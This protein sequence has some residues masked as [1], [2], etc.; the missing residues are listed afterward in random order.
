VL[1]TH[2]QDGKSFEMKG[3]LDWI[4]DGDAPIVDLKTC[5]DA[6][7]DAFGKAAW[8]FKYHVQAALYRD[9]VEAVTGARKRYVLLA[10]E[11]EP[12]FIVQP[13]V[14]PEHLLEQGR[15]EYRDWLGMLAICREAKLWPAYGVDEMEL[16]LP[17]WA[18][19]YAEEMAP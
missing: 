3:R 8:N 16:T 14:V 10:V 1:W 5:R 11:S 2:Q 15:R 12:P 7:I 9:A 6:S 13:Y 19:D 4:G 18:K 17:R